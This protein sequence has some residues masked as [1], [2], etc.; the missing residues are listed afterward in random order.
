[1]A[2]T[3]PPVVPIPD[4]DRIPQR[5]GSQP[6]G[7]YSDNADYWSLALNDSLE[8]VVDA[9]EWTEDTANLTEGWANAA[10]A[11]ATTATTQAGIAT[12]AASSAVASPGTTAT[13]TTS[14]LIETGNKTFTIQSGKTIVVG[15]FMTCAYDATN[16]MYGSVASYSGTTLVINVTQTMGSGTYAAW[17]IALSAPPST[18]SRPTTTV[19]SAYNSLYWSSDFSSA[20]WTKTNCSVAALTTINDAFGGTNGWTLTDATAVASSLL[21]QSA[22]GT[23]VTG[24]LACHSIYVRR[25]T[26]A[27]FTLNCY[28][29]GGV[30]TETNIDCTWNTNTNITMTPVAATLQTGELVDYGYTVENNEWL[31]VYVVVQA[32]GTATA[33]AFRLWPASRTSASMGTLYINRAQ[34]EFAKYTPGLYAYTAGAYAAGSGV[35]QQ[36]LATYSEDVSNAI[37]IKNNCTAVANQLA[38]NGGAV[39]LSTVSRT[40]TGNHFVSHGTTVTTASTT[41]T[42]SVW[43]LAGSMS[44]NIVL[45]IRDGASVEIATLTITPTS[46]PTRYSKTVTFPA[47]SA[48]NIMTLLDPVNDAGSAGDTFFV[49]GLQI[50][51][52]FVPLDY[53]ATTSAAVNTSAFVMESL[54][55]YALSSADAPITVAFP[56]PSDGAEVSF[57]DFGGAASSNNITINPNGAKVMGKNEPFIINQNDRPFYFKYTPPKGWTLR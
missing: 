35:I 44:G 50:V 42:I 41:F 9:L 22:P 28:F 3:P 40:A 56:P 39:S 20:A 18:S 29:T 25:G 16:W 45:R 23:W 34:M 26:S 4:P 32:K 7:Q 30:N 12:A 13:S 36:N 55:D 46:T 52:G 19:S 14:L 54:K 15:M 51:K 5:D 47:G 57:V 48:A 43:V 31:R 17:S 27:V 21:E 24:N 11:S 33:S 10:S 53:V 37:W 38:A 8:G 1:M 6:Q 49:G 2:V